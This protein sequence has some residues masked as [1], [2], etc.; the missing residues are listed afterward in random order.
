MFNSISGR[1]TAKLPNTV[2]LENSGLE[3]DL[4]V[5]GW[6]LDALPPVGQS[7]QVFTWLYH[8]EDLMRMYGFASAAERSLFLDLTKVEGIGPKQ[9]LRI[10]SS[11]SPE[12]L[13]AALDG[14]DLAVLESAPGIG[15]KTAQKMI[16]S[17]KGKL[18]HPVSARAAEKRENL[19][20][21][22]IVTA[23]TGMGY[24]KRQAADAVASAAAS[25]ASA[26]GCSVQALTETG[27]TEKEIFRRALVSLAGA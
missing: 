25:L 17:L 9:A 20:W 11:L 27:E 1:I 12:Q 4:A 13:E 3:W 8:R 21:P 18:T 7:A 23:L 24:D 16:L 19:I 14:E 26:R 6:T 10:L 15:R 2:Y 5:S 22:E